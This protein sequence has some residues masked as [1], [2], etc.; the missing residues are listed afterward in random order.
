MH[1]AIFK[2]CFGNFTFTFRNN[3]HRHNLCLHIGRETGVRQSFNA[4]TFQ[5]SITNYTHFINIFLNDCASFTQFG[6]QRF[7][8]FRK[9]IIYDNIATGH[10]SSNHIS[11]SFD[12][13][14]YNSVIC[15]MKFLH[16]FNTDYIST[17]TT[18]LST[19]FIQIA[20]KSNDFRFFSCVF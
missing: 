1:E 16:P 9:N 11:T 18:N 19:H 6:N 10:S 12:T 15:T 2:N 8:V 3:H 13:V 5:S 17:C 14:G 7:L 20:S 4:Y